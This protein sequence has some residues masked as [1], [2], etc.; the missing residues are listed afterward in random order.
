MLLYLSHK[1]FKMKNMRTFLYIRY[2]MA[3]I[4]LSLIAI[5]NVNQVV[6]KS[7]DTLEAT[8]YPEASYENISQLYWRM[9]RLDI[10]NDDNIDLFLLINE[11]DIYTDYNHN[12]FQWREIREVA[13]EKIRANMKQGFSSRMKFVQPLKLG[14]YNPQE[15]GFK[16][17]E[18]LKIHGIRR[19]EIK[20]IDYKKD[21][22][23]Y[24]SNA[25][26]KGYPKGILAE[27][28]RPI[29]LEYLPM[30]PKVAQEYIRL[31]TIELDKMSVHLKKQEMV[32]GQREVYIVMFVRF[33]SSVG[34]HFVEKSNEPFAKL[35]GILEKIEVYDD[36]QLQNLLY[37][38]NYTRIKRKRPIEDREQAKPVKAKAIEPKSIESFQ[39]TQTP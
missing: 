18:N 6:A 23:A 22:C 25:R 19:F 3:I 37:S 38:Q 33:F 36:L 14:D 13:R 28:S 5:P 39:E 17:V 7:T 31:K 11:C 30:D 2:L 35:L 29:D 4:A 20:T 26:L 24:P 12:E 1:T 34:D 8:E 27:L 16:I 32:E 15:E 10:N 9:N 21:I